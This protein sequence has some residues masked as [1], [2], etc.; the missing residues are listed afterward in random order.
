MEIKGRN[1]VD[2]LPKNITVHSEEV[3]EALLDVPAAR[4]LDAIKDDAGAHPAGAGGRHHRPRHHPDR[5]RRPAARSG[6][7][8]PE[9]DRHRRACCRGPAGLRGQGCRCGAGS[10]GCAA[11]RAGHRR[12]SYVSAARKRAA[13]SLAEKLLTLH[14][15]CF[16]LQTGPLRGWHGCPRFFCERAGLLRMG[17]QTP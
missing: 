14:L 9:R 13:G 5:R 12:R 16:P 2:G 17:G 6:P 11:R 4:S 8:D 3:R 10:C 15:R 7:A 1:L